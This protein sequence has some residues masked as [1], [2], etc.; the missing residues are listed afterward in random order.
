MRRKFPYA[1]RKM[2][3][4]NKPT[5]CRPAVCQPCF[6]SSAGKIKEVHGSDV[7]PVLVKARERVAAMKAKRDAL[8]AAKQKLDD[9]RADAVSAE[10]IIGSAHT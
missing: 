8:D 9:V 4:N 7:C 6:K 2:R 1:P 5:Q 10:E 3:D